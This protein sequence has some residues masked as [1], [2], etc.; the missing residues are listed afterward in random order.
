MKR[1]H[2]TSLFLFVV[3]LLCS[4]LM[5][6]CNE[7]N[8]GKLSITPVDTICLPYQTIHWLHSYYH[9]F[10]QTTVLTFIDDKSLDFILIDLEKNTTFHYPIQPLIKLTGDYSPPVTCCILDSSSALIS[11]MDDYYRFYK[12]DRKGNLLK[13]YELSDVRKNRRYNIRPYDKLILLPSQTHEKEHHLLCNFTY[14]FPGSSNFQTDLT[15]RKMKFSGKVI[16]LLELTDT[17]FRI[18]DELGDFPKKYVTGSESYYTYEPDY[19]VDRTNRINYIFPMDNH[20]Y[21]TYPDGKSYVSTFASDNFQTVAAF[22]TTKLFDYTFI[23]KYLCENNFHKYI[24]NDS[25]RNRIFV[26]STR[27]EKFENPD[28]TVNDPAETPWMLSVLDDRFNSIAEFGFEK[29]Q[30][31]KHYCF[32]NK[33]G[34]CILNHQLT[35]SNPNKFLTFI[36][37]RLV[38]Q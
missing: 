29:E 10:F 38:Y 32:S 25:F 30:F 5:I 33:Q 21:H 20:I 11:F 35:N 4:H 17:S 8:K 19:C 18:V 2:S 28:G 12:I 26:I 23:S 16:S 22:D 9:P 6:S 36:V 7:N 1:Y 37:F 15:I 24:H 13:M 27:I 3:I 31:S 34:L 14:V